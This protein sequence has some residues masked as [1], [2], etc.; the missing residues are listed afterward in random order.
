[1]FVKTILSAGPAHWHSLQR[2][3]A[4]ASR[5]LVQNFLWN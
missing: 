1:M 2:I 4:E 5:V 3:R